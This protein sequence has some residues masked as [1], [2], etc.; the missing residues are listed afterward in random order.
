M[1]NGKW[2]GWRDSNP[3]PLAPQASILYGC[4]NSFTDYKG[5]CV[6]ADLAIW[7]RTG[8]GSGVTR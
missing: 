8:Y 6:G 2:S 5:T 4:G 1:I 3:R 7:Q